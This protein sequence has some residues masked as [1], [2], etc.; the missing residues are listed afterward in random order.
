MAASSFKVL[1]DIVRRRCPAIWTPP[2]ELEEDG[3][4]G[5]YNIGNTCFMN[6]ALQCMA[7]VTPLN[8]YF[9]GNSCCFRG[10]LKNLVCLNIENSKIL[11]FIVTLQITLR[12]KCCW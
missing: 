2:D 10:N 3:P 9:L 4:R 8:S 5:L 7:A 1:P 12:Q 6:A 11:L